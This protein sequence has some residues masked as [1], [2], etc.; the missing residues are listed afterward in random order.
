MSKE[1]LNISRRDFL[2]LGAAGT[3][4]A[5]LHFHQ[6]GTEIAVG[7]ATGLASTALDFLKGTDW[8]R[9][10]LQRSYPTP[11]WLETSRPKRK[12]LLNADDGGRAYLL[13]MFEQPVIRSAVK[14]AY[15]DLFINKG[16]RPK[17]LGD[18]FRQH[19]GY[20]RISLQQN[21]KLLNPNLSH[22]NPE[23]ADCMHVAFYTMALVYSPYLSPKQISELTDNTVNINADWS[24]DGLAWQE[25]FDSIVPHVFPVNKGKLHPSV[26]LSHD[27]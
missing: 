4:A 26:I 24:E 27:V 1:M 2:K 18:A 12:E 17:K 10:E 8:A 22:H 11:G 19:M 14:L 16:S 23:L 9:S 21:E 25:A 6:M 7:T 20:A 15:A 13:D 5:I 3:F